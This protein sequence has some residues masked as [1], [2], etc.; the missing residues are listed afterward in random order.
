MRHPHHARELKDVDD[1]K[2]L[3]TGLNGRAKNIATVLTSV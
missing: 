1:S 3:Y 2:T